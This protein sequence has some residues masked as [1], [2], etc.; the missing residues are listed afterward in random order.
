MEYY[1]NHATYLSRVALTFKLTMSEAFLTH[2]INSLLLVFV[3]ILPIAGNAAS[4]YP[5]WSELSYLER[6][7]LGDLSK[8]E[9]GDPDTLLALYL[10]AS[11]TRDYEQYKEIAKSIATFA[12]TL[13]KVIIEEENETLAAE[14]VNREMHRVFFNNDKEGLPAGYDANQS[15]LAGIFE[16][17]KFNCISSALLYI[18][19][20]RHRSFDVA[21][22][23]LTSHAF[24]QLNTRENRVVDI[25][26]TSPEGFG[27][28]HDKEFYK[29]QGQS[30]SKAR[31]LE[32]ATYDDY[33]NREVVDL[34]TLG[35]R[36]MLNQHTGSSEMLLED[37]G[38]LAELSAYIDPTNEI[39]NEKRLYFYGMTIN[40]LISLEQWKSL[41]SFYQTTYARVLIDSK[42]FLH[43]E[44]LQNNLRL[45]LS[46]AM[47]A[48]AKAGDIERTLDVMGELISRGFNAPEHRASIESRVVIA[49]QLMLKSLAEQNRYK[50][51]L[52]ALSLI[53]GHLH[54]ENINAALAPW[55]HLSWA[56]YE[57]D[58]AEW[59][60]V[61]DILNEYLNVFNV[62]KQRERVLGNLGM[63]YTNEVNQLI[64]YAEAGK[65]KKTVDECL[66]KT[67]SKICKEAKQA[68]SRRR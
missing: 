36:N 47:L 16:N 37:S 15:R 63:A 46:G 2:F 18:V 34:V 50:E 3:L 9:R 5:I 39:A 4:G 28:V 45:Y 41:L 56:E 11:G 54:T 55:F 6:M 10:V 1:R 31:G 66:A 12:K 49:L 42:Q 51:G 68:L 8:A 13:D 48:Y 22:V 40:E 64:D 61:I 67:Y 43:L 32:P 26:T 44:T 59:R 33:L 20:A 38:R 17:H 57:W 27:Q 19:L 21:G 14:L 58:M 65:A 25:E 24:V 23:L 30:W 29:R 60:N 52:L 7:I 53:E 62:P 35:A